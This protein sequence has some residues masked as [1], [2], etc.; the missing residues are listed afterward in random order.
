MLAEP[1]ISTRGL[2][3]SYG[4]T[5]VLDSV[6]VDIAPASVVAVTGP[7]GAGKS[8]FLGCLAGILTHRGEVLVDSSPRTPGSIAF[9][10]QRVQFPSNALVG[11]VLDLFGFEADFPSGFIPDRAG[12][13]SELSGG[14]RRR[15]AVAATLGSEASVTLLD[16]PLA[17]LDD[18]GRTEVVTMLDDLRNRGVTVVVASPTVV[19]LLSIVDRVLVINQGGITFDGPASS[20][21]AGIRTGIWVRGTVPSLPDAE[22]RAVGEWTVITCREDHAAKLISDLIDRGVAPSDIR[23][24]GPDEGNRTG[25]GSLHP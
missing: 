13:M 15:V 18:Q 20:Y 9:L 25:S 12:K 11:E 14:Q 8:T 6:T 4:R 1:R 7:N 3:K 10:P 24:G 23:L 19:D 21:F 5:A 2:G 22:V 16:E 17:N